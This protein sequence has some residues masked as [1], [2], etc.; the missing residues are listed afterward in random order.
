MQIGDN[1]SKYKA[2]LQVTKIPVVAV[3]TVS[4]DKPI[5]CHKLLCYAK[6]F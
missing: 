4:I 1:V 6:P 3:W 2:T 5:A